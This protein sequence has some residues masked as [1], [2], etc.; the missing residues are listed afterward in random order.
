MI[1]MEALENA[2]DALVLAERESAEANAANLSPKA[3][4]DVKSGLQA[5]TAK[6]NDAKNAMA[7]AVSKVNEAAQAAQGGRR[8]RKSRSTRRRRT[9]HRVGGVKNDVFVVY[10][11]GGPESPDFV[12]VF[13]TLENAKKHV[14]ALI[15]ELNK[16]L[17]ED[18][19]F[20]M[21]VRDDGMMAWSES[22]DIAFYCKSVKSY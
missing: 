16:H 22:E 18:K 11:S 13:D 6:Y 12:G 7:V 9:Q 17:E 21:D 2:T 15:G 3:K 8:N 10:K 19:H 4:A 14:L 20:K 5:A 1:A